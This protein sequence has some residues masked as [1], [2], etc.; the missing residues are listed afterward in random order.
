M[1]ESFSDAWEALFLALE[2]CEAKGSSNARRAP[3]WC[4]QQLGEA[5][6]AWCWLNYALLY[7][8]VGRGGESAPLLPASGA[9][10]CGGAAA[11]AAA[12]SVLIQFARTHPQRVVDVAAVVRVADFVV[13]CLRLV[14][15][16][17]LVQHESG[18]ATWS[19]AQHAS[20][21]QDQNWNK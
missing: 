6:G 7:L 9:A 10:T 16:A 17:A 8:E 2:S 4:Q 12:A 3:G 13:Q 5:S 20:L 11:T 1:W 18:G 15:Q 19:R 21:V 14:Q